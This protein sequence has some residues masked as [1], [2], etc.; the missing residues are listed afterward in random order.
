MPTNILKV[1]KLLDQELGLDP[2]SGWGVNTQE[3]LEEE[4][5]KDTIDEL[6]R[7]MDMFLEDT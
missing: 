5:A 2:E 3:K 7:E 6:E 1:E 4:M